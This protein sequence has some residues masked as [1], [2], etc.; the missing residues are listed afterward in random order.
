[1]CHALTTGTCRR[2]A[3]L[4]PDYGADP[5]E[6]NER[7]ID[8]LM[9]HNENRPLFWNSTSCRPGHY[10]P[11]L[12]KERK[13]ACFDS[14]HYTNGPQ[15]STGKFHAMEKLNRMTRVGM[16]QGKNWLHVTNAHTRQDLNYP[17]LPTSKVSKAE[18][19]GCLR[20]TLLCGQK[21]GRRTLTT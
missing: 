1:M 8:T 13:F 15:C 12:S 14:S 11:S 5:L 20:W 4:P 21:T 17:L 18:E 6:T 9:K 7:R 10:S 3:F 2:T 19:A 16:W